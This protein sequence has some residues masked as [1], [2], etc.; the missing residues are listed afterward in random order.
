[1]SELG[2]AYEQL[3]DVRDK[4]KNLTLA[5]NAHN[6]SLKDRTFKESPSYAATQHS[7][8]VVYRKLS[9]VSSNKEEN[10]K[11][12]IDIFNEALKIRTLEEFPYDYATTQGH[13]G[14]AY[15]ELSKVRDRNKEKN[16]ELS[17]NAFN[18][19][20]KGI[21]LEKFPYEYAIIQKNLGAAYCDL[22]LVRDN[23]KNRGLAIG[24]YS[25]AVRGYKEALMVDT[26]KEPSLLFVNASYHLAKAFY[27][28]G[29]SV[30]ALS[31]MKEM[32]PVAEE[33]GHP[34]LEDYRQFY[35]EL[36]STR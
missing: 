19:A 8:G 11:R 29:D 22:S 30:K 32:L 7:L 26:K 12:A 20:L 16:L 31:V 21:P 3:S 27:M 24:A 13:L 4:E 15:V 18:E 6:E 25:E 23:E 35:E 28:T 36:K 33:V 5:M 1:M 14:I 17:V 9:N 34:G 10:L 2:I